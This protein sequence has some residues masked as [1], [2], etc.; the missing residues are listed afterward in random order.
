MN[1]NN[2]FSHFTPMQS[3]R[4]YVVCIGLLLKDRPVLEKVAQFKHFIFLT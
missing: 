4:M 2:T 1:E 3:K